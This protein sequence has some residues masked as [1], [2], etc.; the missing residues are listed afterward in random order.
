MEGD[1][2]NESQLALRPHELETLQKQAEKYPDCLTCQRFLN[3][4]AYHSPRHEAMDFC[5]SGKR[6]HCSCSSCF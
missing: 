4:G 1:E 2:V 3:E 5:R 6:S